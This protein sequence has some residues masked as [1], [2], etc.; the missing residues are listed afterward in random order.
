[1]DRM[2]ERHTT[3]HVMRWDSDPEYRRRRA[4][5]GATRRHAHTFATMPWEPERAD[6][7]PAPVREDFLIRCKILVLKAIAQHKTMNAVL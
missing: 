4:A 5:Y 7:Q 1:M 6:S 2:H 3:L